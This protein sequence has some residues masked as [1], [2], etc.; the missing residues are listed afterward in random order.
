MSVPL[1]SVLYKDYYHP[2]N[3]LIHPCN[4]LTVH[5]GKAKIRVPD[6]FDLGEIELLVDSNQVTFGGFTNEDI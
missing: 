1:P 6:P 3:G 5:A 2:V 4:V